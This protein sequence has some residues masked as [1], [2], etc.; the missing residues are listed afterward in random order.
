[1]HTMYHA[2]ATFVV[3]SNGIIML[4]TAHKNSLKFQQNVM[5]SFLKI[6]R[7]RERDGMKINQNWGGPKVRSIGCQEGV[8]FFHHALM[9]ATD[10]NHVN[11]FIYYLNVKTESEIQVFCYARL[12]P[13]L[14]GSSLSTLESNSA[15]FSLWNELLLNNYQH[16]NYDG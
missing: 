15:G 12:K 8:Q 3:T 9:F 5:K 11:K 4:E 10:M 6:G 2:G 1:M 14:N 16:N 7:R 13:F